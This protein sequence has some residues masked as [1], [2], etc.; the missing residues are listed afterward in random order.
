VRHWLARHEVATPC[1]NVADLHHHS[2]IARPS[3]SA[4]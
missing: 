2:S 1:A 4:R 3:G